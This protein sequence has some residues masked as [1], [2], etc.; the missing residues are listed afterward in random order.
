MVRKFSVNELYAII[1]AKM[2]NKFWHRNRWYGTCH[3]TCK[4]WNIRKMYFFE[5][6]SCNISFF[7]KF[8]RHCIGWQYKCEIEQQI[9]T[10]Q[11]VARG[12]T[13]ANAEILEKEF[14]NMVITPLNTLRWLH[15]LISQFLLVSLRGMS[16]CF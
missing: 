2:I 12:T 8:Q 11:Q 5:T 16:Q 6:W 10:S 4:G 1:G 9:L 15:T 7:P 14:L 3:G 13:P